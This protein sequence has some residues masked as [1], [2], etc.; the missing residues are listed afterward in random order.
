MIN[1]AGRVLSPIL[2]PHLTLAF[3][4]GI[5]CLRCGITP[6]ASIA[7]YGDSVTW[8]YGGL[9]GG[10]VDALA[11]RSG[12]EISDL[13]IPG[14]KVDGGVS[15]ID[16]ALATVPGAR[17]VI[18]L[19]GGNDWIQTFRGDPCRSGCDPS[20]VDAAYVAIGR[21]LTKIRDRVHSQGKR[22]V[23]A[24]Y[25]PSSPTACKN[26]DAPGFKLYQAHLTRLNAETIKIAEELGNPIVRLDELGAIAAN[27]ENYFDCLH[28]S[29][30]GYEML[31]D[32]WV[33]NE[34]KWAP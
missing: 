31:A 3:I 2:N 6:T 7:A 34:D 25:W 13:A 33:Q 30:Q 24:T 27:P 23:F 22:V 26:Y 21:S 15:R 11:N 14:E 18:L 19:H 9:P 16:N 12:Y 10:W 5:T 29:R 4:L 17:V 32:H 28:P 20:T 8:G 1:F